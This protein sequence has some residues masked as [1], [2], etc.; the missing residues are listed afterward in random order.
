MLYLIN[1]YFQREFSSKENTEKTLSGE[2]NS[3]QGDFLI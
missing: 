1:Y 3:N 2:I